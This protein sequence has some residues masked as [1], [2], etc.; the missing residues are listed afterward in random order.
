MP[1]VGNKK[2]AYTAKG[3]KAAKKAALKVGKYSQEV[4]DRTMT[5]EEQDE[6]IAQRKEWRDKLHPTGTQK[7]KTEM[8]MVGSIGTNSGGAVA[9][10]P[11]RQVVNY[12]Q[13]ANAQ[14]QKAVKKAAAKNR[15]NN[16]K[17]AAKAYVAHKVLKAHNVIDDFN[18]Y[19]AVIEE[20]KKGVDPDHVLKGLDLTS[21]T[22]RERAAYIKQVRKARK[23]DAADKKKGKR[24]GHPV[25]SKGRTL[26]GQ[27]IK[28]SSRKA[29]KKAA[30]AHGDLEE[31]KKRLKRQGDA[32]IKKAGGIEK[33]INA[34][35]GENPELSVHLRKERRNEK[36][37]DK[38]NTAAKIRRAFKTH[39]NFKKLTGRGNKEYEARMARKRS[40]HEDH[41]QYDPYVTRENEDD[42]EYRPSRAEIARAKKRRKAKL[43]VPKK[44]K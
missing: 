35:Y 34:D 42:N 36:D 14:N 17:A 30:S 6:M 7:L 40:M 39:K 15:V 4:A 16:K 29:A 31:G 44:S 32:L 27:L 41:R 8:T 18:D 28:P 13:V 20:Y 12:L 25:D 5:Q 22:G 43:V 24:Q 9:K 1:Q 10:D 3:K 33:A 26:K 37:G 21:V 19:C 2:F 23:L 38:R 11:G